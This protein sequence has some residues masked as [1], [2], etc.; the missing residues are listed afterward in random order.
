M[1]KFTVALFGEAEKGA[2][3]TIY[4]L[5]NLPQVH[6]FLGNPPDDS[7]GISLA[8]QLI[9]YG[10]EL[11]F[12]R[13]E[14]EGFSLKDYYVGLKLLQEDSSILNLAAIGMPGMGDSKVIQECFQLCDQK[15]CMMLAN[16]KDLYDF[17][18]TT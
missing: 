14:E 11:I 4:Y 7:L 12:L 13:V 5:K 18:T 2:F 15:K 16:E 1:Q 6:K 3:Q 17:L 10:R 9:N 8:V